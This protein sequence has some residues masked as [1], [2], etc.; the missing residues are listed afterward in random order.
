[1][2]SV[3]YIQV[4]RLCIPEGIAKLLIQVLHDSGCQIRAINGVFKYDSAQSR[5]NIQITITAVQEIPTMSPIS[6]RIE[7]LKL[8]NDLI[9]AVE[10]SFTEN[11]VLNTIEFTVP[12]SERL[13]EAILRFKEGNYLLMGAVGEYDPKEEL[14]AISMVFILNNKNPVGPGSRS[15]EIAVVTIEE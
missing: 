3:K 5:G 7:D 11:T 4:P 10:V 6:V 14:N 9:A 8:K 15:K 12:S 1:M 13:T 2:R